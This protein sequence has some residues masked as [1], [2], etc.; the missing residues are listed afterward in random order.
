[1]EVPYSYLHRQFAKIDPY[2]EDIRAL[3]QSGDFT[4]G[5]PVDEFEARFAKLSHL[6]YAVGVGTGT[7][8]L[9]LSLKA[10]GVGPGDEVITVL[11]RGSSQFSSLA[12]ASS[13][14]F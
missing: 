7:D 13:V 2:L 9:A 10:V 3:V 1:M 8:A 12:N 14:I 6:P 4:L 11:S 5:S